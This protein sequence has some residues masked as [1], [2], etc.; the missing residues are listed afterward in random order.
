MEVFTASTRLHEIALPPISDMF[1][2]SI[3]LAIF[4]W[5]PYHKAFSQ[6]YVKLANRKA[7][8]MARFRGNG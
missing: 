4:D 7:T 6:Y 1:E 2:G 3:T 8:C 5:S